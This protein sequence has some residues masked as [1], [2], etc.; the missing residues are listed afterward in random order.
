MGNTSLQYVQV[1]ED[2]QKNEKLI[3]YADDAI[4]LPNAG[5]SFDTT[6]VETEL[7]AVKNVIAKY[8]LPLFSGKIAPD[9]ASAGVEAY[10][11]DLKA[12]G[13]DAIAQ[14]YTEQYAAWLAA[15]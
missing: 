13:I 12:A 1:G 4:L 11:A 8:H 9:D 3:S 10:K 6:V 7:A 14:A 5:F 2:P 15:K